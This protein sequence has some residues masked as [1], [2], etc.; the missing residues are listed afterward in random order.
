[1]TTGAD[2]IAATGDVVLYKLVGEYVGFGENVAGADV[3]FESVAFGEEGASV[4]FGAS[5]AGAV[6]MFESVPFEEGAIGAT[7]GVPVAFGPRVA[8]ASVAFGEVVVGILG[9]TEVVG[10]K[11]EVGVEVEAS[12]T[13]V[14]SAGPT[15]PIEK[16]ITLPFAEKS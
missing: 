1:M 14:S 3:V 12:G 5:V 8:G 10:A 11:V 4:A 6:V 7:V 15:P 9:A 13:G 2:V 16:D